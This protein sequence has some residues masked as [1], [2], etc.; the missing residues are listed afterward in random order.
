MPKLDEEPLSCRA[1]TLFFLVFGLVIVG[2]LIREGFAA[3][4]KALHLGEYVVP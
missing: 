2:Y 4:S 1:S 3:A